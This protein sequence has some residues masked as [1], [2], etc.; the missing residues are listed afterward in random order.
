MQLPKLAINN[1]QFV[2]IL[3]FLSVLL[4]TLS[5]LNMPRSEDPGLN[6]PFYD[7]V[8]VYPGTS[9]E[10]MEELI[11][12]PIEEVINE[13]EEVDDIRSTIEEGLVIIE[14]EA[15]YGV[16]IDDV[17]DEIQ[18][19]VNSITRD[20]PSG[21]V[22][23]DVNKTNPQDVKILQL[24]LVSTDAPYAELNELGEKL[25][26]K[27]ENIPNIRSVE[28]EACPEEEIRVSLDLQKMSE[29]NIPL[30]QVIGI[31]QGNNANIPGGDI[32]AGNKSFTI[33]TS[34]GYKSL[35][36]IENTIIS[37]FGSQL[38]Y[39]KDIGEVSFDYE[40]Q[41]YLARFNGERA[42]FVTVTQKEG[43]NI[44]QLAEKIEEVQ[45]DFAANLPAHVSM[46][47]AFEQAPAVE[48]RIGDFFTNLLQGVLLV[49]AIIFVFL[50]GRPSLIVM[51]VIPTSIVIAIGILD[52]NGL[53]IQQISI[54]GLVIALGL[55][56]D[57][58][59]VVIENIMRYLKE[60]MDL[61]EAAVKG[62]SEVGWAIISS[63]VTT[64]LSFFPLTQIQSGTGEF[65]K[66]LPLIV[67]FSLTASL[68]L[69]LTFTPLV[70]GKFLKTS[71]KMQM[72]WVDNLLKYLVEKVYEPVLIFSLKKPFIIIVIATLSF[73]GSFALFPLVGVSLFPTADKP[74]LLVDIKLPDGTNIERTS[75]AV[76]YF[77]NLIDTIDYVK[78]YSSNIGNGNARV[79]YNRIPVR[80]K[81]S[82]GQLLI[83]LDYWDQEEFYEFIDFIRE[84]AK[85]YTGAKV[86]VSELKNGPPY[87]APVT[88]KILGENLDT[89]K[90]IAFDVEDMIADTE[91]TINVDNPLAINKTDLKV[92]INKDK[93][94]MSGVALQ[95]ID[96]AVRAGLTGVAVSE[97]SFDNGD[98]Y[99]MVVRLPFDEKPGI[100]DF[101]K[102]YVPNRQG[103]MIPLNQLAS[104]EFQAG[105]SQILHFDL[106]RNANVTADVLDGYNT[107]E[108][109]L[110]V[111]EQLDNYNFPD[112]YSYYVAG[113]METQEDSFGS[114]GQVLIG[115]LIGIFAVLVLQFRS[116]RQ[117]FIVFSAIPLA[118][119]G[120]II[121]LFITGWSF[122][123]FAFV[124]FTSLVGIVINTSI[125]LVDYSNQLVA[126]GMNVQA[127]I[128]KAA[129]TRFTPI[130]LTT[131]TTILGL[132]PLTLTNSGLWSPLGWTIIGGMISSTLLALLIVPILYKWFTKEKQAV[133][134]A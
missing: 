99:D 15:T 17:Y 115:A 116:F 18:A 105:A 83:N 6:V 123:F 28:I 119:T 124:G 11:V 73:V 8:C 117:P 35:P 2:L 133:A 30:Q 84:E 132:L 53:S 74:L 86:T 38:V 96:L 88:I 76:S 21:I 23:L 24:A 75:E 81:K 36:Q 68:V 80:L 130:I 5:F 113:E 43:A 3:V 109:T 125:I 126:G 82:Y 48:S 39:L 59:I 129:K 46:H 79:Y 19:K 71:S 92:N 50:G 62:T 85:Y 44:L 16:D 56:V 114:L 57:N 101:D 118:F 29:L 67:V 1:F 33:Q 26:D 42:I 60:G 10:D 13:V 90:R 4:G 58:G 72:K 7:V 34:G 37:S 131:M 45:S 51:T 22:S 25:E 127:A 47:T 94:G 77:E 93:A 52:M 61:K 120:S 98:K 54:A 100:E 102:I 65:L 20:L 89:L 41:R 122:S 112:G 66:S 12:N 31:L 111:I 78:N 49:G 97:V 107:Q 106:T 95:D 87:E 64:V 40:D 70:A 134:V 104:I 103:Q 91:G 128:I 32:K 55:L 63:T 69:A 110:Q 27:L 9:P 108:V 121:A 14:I